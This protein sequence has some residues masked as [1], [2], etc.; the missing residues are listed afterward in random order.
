[1]SKSLWEYSICNKGIYYTENAYHDDLDYY[2][3]V[4]F[5]KP[6]VHKQFLETVAN[7]GREMQVRGMKGQFRALR[8]L[9][10]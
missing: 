7:V 4:D 6:D 2:Y 10:G 5:D 9:L 1:M 3:V 8:E